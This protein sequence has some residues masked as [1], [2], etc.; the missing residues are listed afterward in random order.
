VLTQEV[1]VLTYGYTVRL[2]IR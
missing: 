2:G 1:P